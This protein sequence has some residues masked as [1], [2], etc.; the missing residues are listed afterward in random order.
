MTKRK[1]FV[2]LYE[3][4]C[5]LTPTLCSFTRRRGYGAVS[6]KSRRICLLSIA[7]KVLAKIMPNRLVEHIS[8]SAFPKTQC[9]FRKSRSTSDMICVSLS[10]CGKTPVRVLQ[11]RHRGEARLCLSNGL[12]QSPPLSHHRPRPPCPG[13]QSTWST[14]LTE[15]YS[16]SDSSRSIQYIDKDLPY[17]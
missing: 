13:T 8:E 10:P 9:G 6:G 16:T 2:L 1:K 7:G 14:A 15:G 3:Q 12:V 17:L 4:F 11:G 5:V